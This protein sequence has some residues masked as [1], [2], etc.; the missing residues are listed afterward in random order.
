MAERL[1]ENQLK[2][3]LLQRDGDAA[4]I[5][6]TLH[7]QDGYDH[8]CYFIARFMAEHSARYAKRV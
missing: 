3:E 6:L 2:P 1:L 8:S 4:D 5:P 7:M